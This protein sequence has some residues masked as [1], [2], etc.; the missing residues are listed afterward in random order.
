MVAQFLRLP[1]G[2]KTV[3]WQNKFA[4][5]RPAIL[6]LWGSLAPP[7]CYGVIC[8]HKFPKYGASFSSEHSK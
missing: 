3:T 5:G 4:L 7:A 1:R 8:A 6:P 2:G